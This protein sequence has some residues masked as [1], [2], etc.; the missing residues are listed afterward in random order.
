MTIIAWEIFII[1]FS[2]SNSWQKGGNAE[3]CFCLY[4]PRGYV[5]HVVFLFT[6]RQRF[7]AFI[8]IVFLVITVS[9]LFT[10]KKKI[11]IHR[12]IRVIT[13]ARLQ[14]FFLNS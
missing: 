14:I 6:S 3:N 12:N 7:P 2:W 10:N 4:L 5:K 9:L 13:H 1:M 11:C 8:P